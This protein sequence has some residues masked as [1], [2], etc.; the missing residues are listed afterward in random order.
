MCYV[1]YFSL[2]CECVNKYLWM[3][4]V[5]VRIRRLNS[6]S[7]IPSL[8]SVGYFCNLFWTLKFPTKES[9]LGSQCRIPEL[10]SRV[11]IIS[12][13]VA[14]IFKPTCTVSVNRKVFIS[15][16]FPPLFH[17]FFEAIGLGYNPPRTARTPKNFNSVQ[18]ASRHFR[19]VVR[20]REV[21]ASGNSR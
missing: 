8:E 1:F 4:N 6:R 18:S 10:E 11:R 21:A 5:K 20:P 19:R 12:R 9:I 16:Y 7:K 17:S 3:W 2:L 13:K 15:V 14:D